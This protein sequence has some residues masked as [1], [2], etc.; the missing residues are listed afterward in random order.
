M[1]AK[2]NITR[3][4]ALARLGLT[5]ASVYMAPGIFGVSVAHASSGVSA[6][7]PPSP[8]SPASP[9][10]PASNPSPPSGPSRPGSVNENADSCRQPSLPNGGQITRQEYDR[11]QQ[12]IQRGDARPLRDVLRTVEQDYPGRLLRVRFSGRGR[13]H[14]F[15]VTIVN[16]S[17]AIVSVTVDA[18]TGQITNVQNC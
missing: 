3:R 15:R 14:E 7:S 18:K 13:S 6:A 2:P 5:A 11:A 12:A 9:P 8:A 1:T 4:A 16:P 17:G 10:S